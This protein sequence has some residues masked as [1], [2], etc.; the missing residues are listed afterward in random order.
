LWE[1]PIYK[2]KIQDGEKKRDIF[3]DVTGSAPNFSEPGKQLEG[4]L[5]VLL[6]DMEPAKTKIL[7]FGG[8]KLRNTLFLLKKGYTVYSCEFEDL[9]KRSKQANDFLEECKKYKNFQKLVFPSDFLNFKS[10]F[11][12]VLLI[13]VLN[14]MPVPIERYAVLTLCRQKIKNDGKLLWYTQ[15][16]MYSKTDSVADLNDGIV[17]GK[18]RKFNMFYRDFSREE[19]HSMV[20]ANGFTFSKATFFPSSGSNQAYM[21]EANGALLVDNTLG[22]SE[23]L[24]RKQKRSLKPIQRGTWKGTNEEKDPSKR[25]YFTSIPKKATKLTSV[26]LLQTY[27]EELK[28]IVPGKKE[29]NKYHKIIFNIL[30]SIFDGRL[31]RPQFEEPIANKTQRVDITFQNVREKGFFKQLSEGYQIVCPNIYIECK[32]Y[33]KDLEN[34]EYSQIQNRLNDKRGQFGI[35]I[36][37]GIDDEAAMKVRQDNL[38]KAKDYVIVLTDE[39]IEKL[40]EFKRSGEEDEIDDYLEMKFKKLT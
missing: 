19:I 12:V 31:R 36:C 11:D 14:I 38:L 30:K 39:D 27:I 40:V 17:T 15:H 37:R 4:T 13:N 29:A 7:D 35:I 25:K 23:L 2:F 33:T 34:P 20:T 18:G 16:S 10:T 9:F 26:D 32:N 24:K 21:F 6:K 1:S 22:L 8:A 28:T 3:I 5:D